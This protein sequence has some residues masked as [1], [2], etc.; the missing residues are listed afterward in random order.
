MC[1]REGISQ[2]IMRGSEGFRVYG[3]GFRE[4][5]SVCMCV[6]EDITDHHERVG[7]TLYVDH[8]GLGGQGSFD[9]LE[10]PDTSFQTLVPY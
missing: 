6:R 4:Y 5:L 7:R 8:L 9:L 3:S 2:T 10:I 1:V